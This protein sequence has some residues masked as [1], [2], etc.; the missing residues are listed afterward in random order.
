MTASMSLGVSASPDATPPRAAARTAHAGAAPL[1]PVTP[2]PAR[3]PG[4]LELRAP[5]AEAGVH[6]P[7]A[8]T[9]ESRDVCLQGK[10]RAAQ[11]GVITHASRAT[12]A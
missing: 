12:R 3:S 4:A 6:G 5:R 10:A 9:W 11:P 2:A 1:T 8:V 7:L